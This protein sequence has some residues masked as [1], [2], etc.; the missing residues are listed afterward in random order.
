MKKQNNK[1][2]IKDFIFDQP[3]SVMDNNLDQVQACH[4]KTIIRMKS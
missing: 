4:T 2:S 3:V 1:N